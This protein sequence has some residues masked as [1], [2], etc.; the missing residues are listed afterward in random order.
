MLKKF[1]K[2]VEL[3]NAKLNETLFKKIMEGGYILYFRH[4]ETDET[5][6]SNVDLTRCETQR[7]LNEHGRE[8]AKI[9]GEI[10]KKQKL[11]IE[12]PV[13]TSPY[14]RTKETGKIAFDVTNIQVH[15]DLGRID[16]L[17]RSHLTLEEQEIKNNLIKL[18]ETLPLQGKNKVFIAHSAFGGI[19]YMGMVVINPGGEGNKY[20]IVTKLSYEEL[21]E[22]GNN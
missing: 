11:P 16:Y 10:L 1:R 5:D 15:N 7:N 3:I 17:E 12:L 20:E 21:K 19:P 18:F 2:V 14:C 9:I 8:Q 6:E 22:W 4:G 13:L